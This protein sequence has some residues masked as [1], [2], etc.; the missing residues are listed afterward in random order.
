MAAS[1][2]G[3]GNRKKPL[4][5]IQTNCITYCCIEDISPELTTLV[6]IALIA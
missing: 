4:T 5:L 6:V 3:G 1:F 2:I